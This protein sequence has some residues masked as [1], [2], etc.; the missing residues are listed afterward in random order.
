MEKERDVLLRYV[1]P[2]L[3]RRSFEKGISVVE[4]DLR[5]GITSHMKKNN[6]LIETCLT[7]V[8]RCDLFAG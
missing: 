6:Q 7:Q 2:E 3:K 8:Q 4:C 1:I 5:W